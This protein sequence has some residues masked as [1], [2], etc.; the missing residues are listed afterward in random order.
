MDENF[1]KAYIEND[2]E[3]AERFYG[4]TS[5]MFTIKQICEV[6]YSVYG[7]KMEEEYPGFLD[8]LKQRIAQL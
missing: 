5:E 2:I 1:L 7:E 6:W 4:L 3:F 8:E